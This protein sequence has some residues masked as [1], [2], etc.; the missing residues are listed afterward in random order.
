MIKRLDK[1]LDILQKDIEDAKNIQERHMAV[2]AYIEYVRHTEEEYD[3]DYALPPV[4]RSDPMGSVW[5]GGG[6]TLKGTTF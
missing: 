2:L 6:V 4:I 3:D 1:I 5:S